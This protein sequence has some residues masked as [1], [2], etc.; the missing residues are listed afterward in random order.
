MT[1]SDEPRS[2]LPFE[3]PG[4]IVALQ[5]KSVPAPR[6]V[7]VRHGETEWSVTGQHTGRTDIPLT[8]NGEEQARSVGRV[9]A[10]QKFGLV[11]TSPRQRA[12]ATAEIA[13]FGAQAEIDAD[14]AEWDYGAYEGLTSPQIAERFGEPW[15]LWEDGIETD[16][17]GRG[18]QAA[19]LLRRNTAIIERARRTLNGGD[20]VLLFSHG[21]YLRTLAATWMG[22]PI[23]AGELVVLDTASI[24]VLGF[25]HGNQVL[26]TWNRTPW[27]E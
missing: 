24:S 20:D 4:A 11:L 12:T 3:V 10:G 1:V 2:D 6:V 23:R 19:D 14:L 25:E 27:A 5:P 26:R 9:L 7:L 8:T 21:H 15:N 16:A 18:E 13:G 17:E 22:L